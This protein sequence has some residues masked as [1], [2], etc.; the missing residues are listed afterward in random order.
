MPSPSL[1]VSRPDS[2]LDNPLGS[3]LGSL[4]MLPRDWVAMVLEVWGLLVLGGL[5]VWV[6]VLTFL[7]R[8]LVR[9]ILIGS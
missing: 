7:V 9:S 6:W 3:P 1:S 8:A 5:G 2:P 4:L